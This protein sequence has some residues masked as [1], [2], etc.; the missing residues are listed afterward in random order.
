MIPVCIYLGL[1]TLLSLA[2]LGIIRF[3]CKHKI[4]VRDILFYGVATYI[5]IANLAILIFPVIS[6]I[7]DN[8]DKVEY[9]LNK[10]LDKELF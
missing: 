2:Y 5:P 8:S 3:V 4:T 1:C 6:Y 7:D 10:I 9:I